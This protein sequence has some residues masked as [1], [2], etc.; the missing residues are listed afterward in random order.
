MKMSSWNVTGTRVTEQRLVNLRT[1]SEIV[2]ASLSLAFG[3][4]DGKPTRVESV[5][6]DILGGH[7][8]LIFP[9]Y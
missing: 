8:N 2:S 9:K 3:R 1:D 7:H 4:E 5:A 6:S